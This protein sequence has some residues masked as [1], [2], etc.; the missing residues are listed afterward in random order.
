MTTEEKLA[1][2]E[3]KL[4]RALD[5]LHDELLSELMFMARSTGQR[6]RVGRK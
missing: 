3:W 5:R 2:L 6:M 4:W 1:A